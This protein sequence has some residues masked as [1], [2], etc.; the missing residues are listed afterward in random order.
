MA[1]Q[2]RSLESW[3]ARTQGYR[4]RWIRAYGSEDAALEAYRNGKSL[5]PAQRGHRTT[6]ERPSRALQRPYL[7]PKYVGTHTSQLNEL[8]RQRGLREHGTGPRGESELT[9][10]YADNGDFTWMVPVGTLDGRPGWR[11]TYSF[12]TIEEAQQF[13]RRSGAPAG[14]VLIQDEGPETLYRYGVWFGYDENSLHGTRR[15]KSRSK[16]KRRKTVETDKRTANYEKQN[17]GRPLTPAQK[18]RI[19]KNENR[20]KGG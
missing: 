18:K 2:G 3:N 9:R 14:V 8:A 17:K 19:R 10:D 20:K 7:Y 6:P 4:N 16:N 13:A 1:G 15:K 5:T 11:H 12:R